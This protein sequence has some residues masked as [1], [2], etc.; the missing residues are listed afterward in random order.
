M[1]VLD[2]QRE[3]LEAARWR[4]HRM[5]AWRC[6]DLWGPTF[7]VC[8]V[9]GARLQVDPNP[10]PNGIDISGDAVAIN[11]HTAGRRR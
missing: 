1:D 9:C 2:L 3:G 8:Q 10:P 5:G 4:G 11:C 6:P 7:S